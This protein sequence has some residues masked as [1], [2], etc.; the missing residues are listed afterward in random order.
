MKVPL[1][2][3]GHELIEPEVQRSILVDLPEQ[4]RPDRVT[5]HQ[6]VEQC[7]DLVPIPNELPLDCG[8]HVLTRLDAFED[9]LDRDRR[10][11]GHQLLL[12]LSRRDVLRSSGADRGSL[13]DLA[14]TSSEQRSF[15]ATTAT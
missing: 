1:V 13:S 14:A 10:L 6:A 3:T 2:V 11:K 12:R 15:P 4:E 9:L 8:Q 7:A 5:A